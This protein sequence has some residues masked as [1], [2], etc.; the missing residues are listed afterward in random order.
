MYSYVG[1]VHTAAAVKFVNWGYE[2]YPP[3]QT[4]PGPRHREN[5]RV[6]APPHQRRKGLKEGGDRWQLIPGRILQR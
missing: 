2:V 1:I 6:P 3:Q 4:Q 5:H